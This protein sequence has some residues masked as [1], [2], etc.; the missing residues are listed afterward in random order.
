MGRAIDVFSVLLLVFGGVA[1]ALAVLA[2]DDSR[3]LHALYWL[4]VGALLL[5][6]AVEMLRPSRGGRA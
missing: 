5:K 6:A 3:D 1:F 4:L 2:L